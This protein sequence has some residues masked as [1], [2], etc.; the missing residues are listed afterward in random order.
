MTKFASQTTVSPDK[1][2]AEIEA[3][4]KR[5]GASHY[6]YMSGP[7]A[8][9]IA[10]QAKDR[11]LRF[12][13]PMPKLSEFKRYKKRSDAYYETVRT[14]VQAQQH[15]DQAIRQR[16]RALALVIK[17]KLEAVES[18]VSTF[19]EEFMANIV[20]PSGQTMAEYALP[21]IAQAYETGSMPPL[22]GYNG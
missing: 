8:A 22:L 12:T 3:T 10:F 1:S 15:H 5:Y 13:L 17:A 14:D 16:W 18:G 11:R 20:L 4:L 7:D 9:A 21:Q 6:G 19:E 2:R